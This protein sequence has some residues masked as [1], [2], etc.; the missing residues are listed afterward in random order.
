[1][2]YRLFVSQIAKSVALCLVLCGG[3]MTMA[4]EKGAAGKTNST[5]QTKEQSQKPPAKAGVSIY[6]AT[7][8]ELDTLPGVGPA[9]GKRIIAFREEH[10]G[11]KTVEELMNVSGIGEKT[12]AKLKDQITL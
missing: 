6:K 10:G 8:D 7:L 3:M 4:G 9:I 1:M 2:N 12:Y 5:E 11:F